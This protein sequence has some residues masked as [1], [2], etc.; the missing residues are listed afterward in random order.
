[1]RLLVRRI[2]KQGRER[3]YLIIVLRLHTRHELEKLG[4]EVVIVFHPA[5]LT[6]CVEMVIDDLGNVSI[7]YLLLVVVDMYHAKSRTLLLDGYPL[8]RDGVGNVL[9]LDEEF[10]PVGHELVHLDWNTGHAVA[11]AGHVECEL[12]I[13]PAVNM[14]ID[15]VLEL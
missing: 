3:L 9:D 10:I 14:L 11:T 4:K 13:A 7:V 2:K 12:N 1:M 8:V 6:E 15:E 5:K